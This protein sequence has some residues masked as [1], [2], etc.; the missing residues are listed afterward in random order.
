MTT[1]VVSGG[2][3]GIGRA[4]AENLHD[5]GDAIIIVDRD[6]AG[7]AVAENL[8]GGAHFVEADMSTSTGPQ[9]SIAGC[10]SLTKGELDVLYFGPAVLESRRLAEWT[11]EDWDRSLSVNLRAA[12][13]VCQAAETA[14]RKSP[15]GRIVLMSSTGAFRGHAGMH[16]YHASKS[17]MLGLVRSLADEFAPS[18][19][20]NAVC[21]GWIDTPFNDSFW[22]FQEDPKRAREQIEASSP[23]RRQGQPSDVAGIINFLT[24]PEAS[25]ITGQSVTVDGGYTAV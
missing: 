2:A 4:V 7:K 18:V 19:T 20:V 24:T 10:L 13:F 17:G 11:V 8:G 1:S 22:T 9:E 25:Y 21:P 15:L 14:L 16:A 6:T 3:S 5:R 23:A 12:F